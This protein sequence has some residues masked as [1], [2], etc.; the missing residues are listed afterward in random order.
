MSG[1]HFAAVTP[2]DSANLPAACSDF[3]I[4]TGGAL[5]VTA[6]GDPD[7]AA[8]VLPAVAAGLLELPWPVVKIWATGTSASGIIGLGF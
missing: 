3:W 7:T 4:T 6:Q 2:S 5:K 8:V 1:P